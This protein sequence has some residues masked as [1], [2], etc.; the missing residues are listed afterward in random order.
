VIVRTVCTGAFQEN[1]YLVADPKTLET[2][3]I[4]PGEGVEEI[5]A[6]IARDH[7]KPIAITNTHAHIDHIH[8]VA[9]LKK[10]FRIP[11]AL[12]PDDAFWLEAAPEAARAFG[13][14]FGEIPAV[15]RWLA[16]G[17]ELACGNLRFQVRHAP[18]HTP[19][20]LCFVGQGAAFV[21][22]VLFP[23]SIGRTDLPGGDYATLIASIRRE[24]MTL[25]DETVVYA[26]HMEPTT[27]GR[28]RETNPF[29]LNP[30]AYGRVTPGNAYCSG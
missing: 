25:P 13:I 16:P 26:G 11:F 23:G 29:V 8:G 10:R 30:E 18:G 22:D 2:L 4:D 9:A 5:E 20:H 15:D 21:G 17:A 28:E 12:H 27:V 6:A 19:G 14:R 7:L 1:C 24:L 3:V